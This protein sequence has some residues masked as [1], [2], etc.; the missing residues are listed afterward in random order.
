MAVEKTI[1]A[2]GCFWGMEEILRKIPGVLKTTVGY[3]GG[4]TEN[5]TYKEV[6]TGKTG[7]A[8]AIEIEFE[9]TQIA[10]EELLEKYFFRMHDPTTVDRQ[11]HDVGSQYRSV[12]FYENEAQRSTAE[13][14][15]QTFDRL[16][17]W[18]KPIVTQIV[19]APKFWSAE[20]YHQD[21][22]EK[23]PGGYTCHYIRTPKKDLATSST[24]SSSH[25]R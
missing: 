9:N 3:A 23:N 20:E 2:G 21:Y 17:F 19:P 5:P 8:E 7:H 11:G 1:L 25:P 15:K 13:E 14:V 22:L 12:I 10:F 6:C 24:S 4:T 18:D 16:G